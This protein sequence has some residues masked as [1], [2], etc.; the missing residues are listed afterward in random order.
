MHLFWLQ[1]YSARRDDDAYESFNRRGYMPSD[2]KD[3]YNVQN[4]FSYSR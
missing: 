3:D 2:D 1:F 4:D